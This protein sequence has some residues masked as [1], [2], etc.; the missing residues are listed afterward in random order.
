MMS[1]NE[2]ITDEE[3]FIT[4]HTELSLGVISFA[5]QRIVVVVKWT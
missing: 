2:F 4:A 5:T 3:R 1:Y